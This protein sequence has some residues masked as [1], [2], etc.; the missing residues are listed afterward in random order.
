VYVRWH[1]FLRDLELLQGTIWVVE[2]S[3]VE[4]NV[5]VDLWGELV[6]LLGCEEVLQ[7]VLVFLLLHVDV[8]DSP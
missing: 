6:N 1:E 3:V 8:P 4:T 7:C 5:S 2:L